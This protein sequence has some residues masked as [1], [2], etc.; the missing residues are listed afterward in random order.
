MSLLKTKLIHVELAGEYLPLY[1][2]ADLEALVE[3]PAD[4]DQ[5]PCWAEAWPAARG[6]AS[7]FL[8]GSPLEGKTVLELG[9]GVGLPGVAC[10]LQNAAV[11][12]SD[13]QQRALKIC[14]ANARLYR[15][16]RYRLLL[17]DWRDFKCRE[18][19]DLVLASDIAYEPRLLP[20]L[21]AV[22]LAVSKPGGSIYFSHPGRPVTFAFIE[23]LLA[24]AFFHEERFV[25]PVTVPDDPV[26]T[27]YEIIIHRLQRS[28]PADLTR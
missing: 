7:Y 3:D 18:R 12:F 16:E 25:I 10:G 14:D 1:V 17:A 8:Q 28:L 13:F 6:L 23:E 11:T 24:D 27:T 22:L 9:A 19:F 2:A 15:L 26:R 21:K 5:V 20:S 4:P